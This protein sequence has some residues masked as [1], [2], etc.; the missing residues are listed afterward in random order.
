M[1]GAGA[2]YGGGGGGPSMKPP[3]TSRGVGTQPPT[4]GGA[5][6]MHPAAQASRDM[7][8]QAETRMEQDRDRRWS[9]YRSTTA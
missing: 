4:T 7:Q 8:A 2:G 9:A 6:P 1:K 3:T 5:V